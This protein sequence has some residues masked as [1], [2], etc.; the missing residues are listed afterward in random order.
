VSTELARENPFL[1]ESRIVRRYR[2]ADPTNRVFES[3]LHEFD[4]FPR[5]EKVKGVLIHQS[6]LLPTPRPYFSVLYDLFN[7]FISYLVGMFVNL[8]ADEQRLLASLLI[9]LFVIAV[10]FIWQQGLSSE[11]NSIWLVVITVIAIGMFCM[12]LLSYSPSCIDFSMKRKRRPF[13]PLPP[14]EIVV[15]Q[16]IANADDSSTAMA[17][18]ALKPEVREGNC[19]FTENYYV[20]GQERVAMQDSIMSEHAVVSNVTDPAEPVATVVPDKSPAHISGLEVHSEAHSLMDNDDHSLVSYLPP[21]PPIG[22]SP[23]REKPYGVETPADGF[24]AENS[25]VQMSEDEE[26]VDHSVNLSSD[27]SEVE[28]SSEEEI[29]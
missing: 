19:E 9:P 14:K 5:L 15:V 10:L 26:S 11:E 21:A 29:L 23:P 1:L 6:S 7:G 28:L 13:V 25:H 4:H 27:N 24:S 20:Q 22:G 8:S 12:Y 18:D 3:F 17:V 16:P 2:S